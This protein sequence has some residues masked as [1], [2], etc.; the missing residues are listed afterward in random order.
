MG[1]VE[2]WNNLAKK[3]IYINESLEIGVGRL[4]YMVFLN[5]FTTMGMI[6]SI[7]TPASIAWLWVDL[8]GSFKK[9]EKVD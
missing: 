8:L 5:L 1:I 2:K 9:K 7:T 6:F 4:F 3:K